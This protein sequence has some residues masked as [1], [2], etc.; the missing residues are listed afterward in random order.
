MN[1]Y[2]KIIRSA[3]VRHA[4][5]SFLSF[6]PEK[7][8]IKLQYRI[9]MCKRLNLSNPQTYTEKLQWYKLYYHNPLMT[10]WADK[11]LVREYLTA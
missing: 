7:L 1:G 6:V 5:L 8:M 10:K 4:I 9:K 11:H 3:K 2:K